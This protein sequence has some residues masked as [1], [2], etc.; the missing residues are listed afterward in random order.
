MSKTYWLAFGNGN[1]A[2]STGLSPTFT[3]FAGGDG[4]SLA[5][6]P[7]ITEIPSASGLYRF[8]Y[9]PTN[10]IVFTVDGGAALATA[11]RYIGGV[12]DPIQAVDEK[13]GTTADSFGSTATDPSSVFGYLKRHLEWLEGEAT[14]TKSTGL[15]D[16]YSRG[17]STLLKEKTLT[18]TNST[19]TKA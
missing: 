14:F 5:T 10:S 13:V 8:I 6:P 7:G 9:G 1:P 18:N 19:A 2:S 15:W 11:D 16:V 4:A 3:V 17:S 12:L